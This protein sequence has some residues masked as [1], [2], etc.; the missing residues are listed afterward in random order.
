MS[1]H[2]VKHYFKIFFTSQYSVINVRKT[3]YEHYYP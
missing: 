2:I 1:H 3:G